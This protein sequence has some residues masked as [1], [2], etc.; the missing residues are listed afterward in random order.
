MERRERG[1]I[2]PDAGS[3]RPTRREVLVLAGSGAGALLLSRYAHA[4]AL[5]SMPVEDAYIDARRKVWSALGARPMPHGRTWMAV[6]AR[7]LTDPERIARALP[8]PLEPDDAPEVHIDWFMS[9]PPA[10]LAERTVMFPGTAYGESDIFLACKYKGKSCLLELELDMQQDWGRTSGRESTGL[11][12]KVGRVSVDFDGDLARASL[13]RYGRVIA[14]IET[15]LTDE[16]AHPRSWFREV[17]EGWL[18]YCWRLHPDWRRGPIEDE[19]VQ[20]WTRGGAVGGYPTSVPD[21]DRLPRA[22]DLAR[23]T[24]HFDPCALSAY[25]EFPVREW[26]GVSGNVYGAYPD[27]V[28]GVLQRGDTEGTVILPA[29]RLEAEI[30]A[31]DLEPWALSLRGYDRPIT[32]GK[33]WVPDGWPDRGSAVRL[34]A[35]EIERYRA[36]PSY[37]LQDM[38]LVDITYELDPEV[39]RR[40]LPPPCPPGERP[41][42]RILAIRVNESDFSPR[43]FVELWLMSRCE[44]AGA[45][46][47][48]A[49]SHIVGW[50]GD[51]CFGRETFGYPSKLGEP[52]ITSDGL[53]YNIRGRRLYRDFF[54]AAVP[55]SLAPPGA[56]RD[57]FEV[58]GIHTH[59]WQDTPRADIVGQPWTV[60][61]AAAR[62]ANL[63]YVELFFPR[64]P[65]HGK[66]GLPDPWFELEPR[67]LLAVVAGSGVMRRFPCRTLA[68]LPGFADWFIERLDGGSRDTARGT[69]LDPTATEGWRA[70]FGP[71]GTLTLI[72][73]T[74]G[75]R[76]D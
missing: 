27:H 62:K 8:P 57:R 45:P 46:A 2:T 70:R 6:A 54:Q 38:E 16:P 50:D 12:K 66:I 13:T 64:T 14:A 20:L 47:W 4:D 52:E 65:S 31:S 72:K 42:A 1:I 21:A 56:H 61:I 5:A 34:S 22:G 10:D 75:A 29:D 49:L 11:L 60:E 33:V 32:R 23:T 55:L 51:V 53:Q 58:L 74:P 19:V 40:T 18:Y 59:P 30:S 15:V 69:F 9:L 3:Q 43:P 71:D 35:A 7:Y 48:Y 76:A 26:V 73:K 37:D 63:P 67:R 25:G 17:G 41:E 68:D 28:R 36:R 39:H 24:I 44:V